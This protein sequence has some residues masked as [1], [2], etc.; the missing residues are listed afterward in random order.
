MPRLELDKVGTVCFPRLWCGIHIFFVK[1]PDSAI[2]FFFL[3]LFLIP[4]VANSRRLFEC[5]RGIVSEESG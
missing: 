2:F 1:V 3:S 5:D 4:A